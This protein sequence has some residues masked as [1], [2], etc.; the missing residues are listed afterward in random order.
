MPCPCP[1]AGAFL[2]PIPPQVQTNQPCPIFHRT[3]PA[4]YCV[5]CSG[6][7]S[8]SG[9][10]IRPHLVECS[11]S[12][13]WNI[14]F[15]MSPGFFSHPLRVNGTGGVSP[16]PRGPRHG[17]ENC[18]C[19]VRSTPASSGGPGRTRRPCLDLPLWPPSWRPVLDA[20]LRSR[21]FS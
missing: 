16:A 19:A 1:N 11:F 20:R 3:F 6:G 10:L 12:L 8:Y 7:R 17:A 9:R 5:H 15:T 13:P 21:Q 18:R 2:C 14:P 4:H